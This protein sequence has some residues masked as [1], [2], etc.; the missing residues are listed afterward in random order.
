[1]SPPIAPL[2]SPSSPEKTHL[3]GF[4]KH[5]EEKYCTKFPTYHDLHQWSV[6]HHD[7]FWKE[8]W[9]FCQIKGT[10]QAT[11]IVSQGEN[12]KDTT[13]FEDSF[14]NFSEN[15]LG[16][17]N[18]A[19]A[20]IEI[21]EKEETQRYHFS[22]IHE[23]VRRLQHYFLSIGLKKG[24]RVAGYLP[25]THHAV[26]A[27]LACASIGAL[28]T[29][30]SPD[31]GFEGVWERFSQVNPTVLLVC[32]GYYYNGKTIDCRQ[33]AHALYQSLPSLKS[34][35][36]VSYVPSLDFVDPWKEWKDIMDEEEK[37]H[38][39]IF[40]KLPFNHPLY[41]L[42]SSGTTGAPKAIVHGAGGT[43]I[44]HRKEHML[45]SD[46]R[47]HDR[48]FYFTTTSWM[49]WHWLISCLA[50]RASIVLYEG[51][52]TYPKNDSLLKRMDALK[53]SFFGTSAK[54]IESLTQSK[55]N[56]ST[57]YRFDALRTIG[58]TGSPLSPE[59][60]SYIYGSIKADVHLS[61]LSGGTDIISC[62]ALGN[63]LSPVYAGQLQG[64]GLG[65]DIHSFDRYGNPCKHTKGELV[66]TTP[67]PSKPLYFWNDEG[68]KKYDNAYFSKDPSLWYHGDFVE[69]TEQKGWIFHGRSDTTLNPG[70]VRIGTAEIYN[71]LST[72]E[73]IGEAVVVGKKHHG[74]DYVILCI[75]LNEGLVLNEDMEKNIKHHIRA[76]TT[77]RHVPWRIF[78]VTGV[79]KTRNG[80]IS[81]M[82]ISQ[83]FNH[84][85]VQNTTALENPS[86][87]EEYKF[88]G[89]I[90]NE[91][92]SPPI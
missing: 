60:F 52:P 9:D 2:W 69:Y 7:S 21:N 14:L 90:I 3:Y 28:W 56:Y 43:L 63:P 16:E 45:Q 41:I 48:I 87:L 37:D 27:M 82:A 83:I 73:G 80:K 24:D 4:L 70:G 15:V 46:I 39:L 40:E 64:A 75:V 31:F 62:F 20:I 66:C 19:L 12:F 44:Q 53:V 71:A 35:I 11:P 74:E 1:M 42:Y 77:P 34:C 58:S 32:N 22:H 67:F 5:I 33:K 17:K 57:Q 88:I 84:N 38:T 29:A 6:E 47:P 61:S 30:C 26:V 72:F 18:D 25:N 13:F 50:Q 10:L 49:M 59:S 76:K 65:M 51:C 36:S 92:L 85:A 81:E 89:E 55:K 79:A 78:S 86:I 54:F 68:G 23:K 8:V 91:S